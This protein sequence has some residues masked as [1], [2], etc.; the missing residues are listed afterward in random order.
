MQSGLTIEINHTVGIYGAPHMCA[1]QPFLK[2]RLLQGKAL[3]LP[4]G[5]I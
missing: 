5:K 3:R 2:L 1:F 4:L